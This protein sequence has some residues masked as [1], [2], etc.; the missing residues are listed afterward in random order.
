MGWRGRPWG[1]LLQPLAQPG[2]PYTGFPQD[3]RLHGN[4]H[5]APVEQ[6]RLSKT[7][8]IWQGG[9][10][11]GVFVTEQLFVGQAA[12]GCCLI[13]LFSFARSTRSSSVVRGYT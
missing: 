1:D 10:C 12:L 6:P 4:P 5:A 11:V 7:Y 9:F 8:L 2:T 13:L 3:G